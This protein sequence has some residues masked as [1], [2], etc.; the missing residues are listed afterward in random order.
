[1]RR[2]LNTVT[3]LAV[4]T[5]TLISE[6]SCGWEWGPCPKT[7]VMQNFNLDAYTGMW[8]EQDRDKSVWYETGDCVQAKYTRQADGSV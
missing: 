3:T 1:M 4:L 5:L 2:A 8:Y 6:V 7:Q